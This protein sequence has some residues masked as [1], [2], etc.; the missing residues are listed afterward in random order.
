M[1]AIKAVLFDMDGV[2]IDSES[3]YKNRR[4]KFLKK[5]KY[6]PHCSMEF[7]GFNERAI[8]ETLVPE[9]IELREELHSQYRKYCIKNPIDYLGYGNPQVYDVFSKLKHDG[10]L[11]AVCSSSEPIIIS[12]FLHANGVD[13]YVDYVISGTQ[14]SQ[15]K[16]S[17]EIYIRAISALHVSAKQCLIVEDSS[18]GITAANASDAR[19]VRLSQYGNDQSTLPNSGVVIE[20]LLDILSYIKHNDGEKFLKCKY[21]NCERKYY[22]SSPVPTN[23]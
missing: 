6:S 3:F 23:L 2:L 19:V 7:T 12:N 13:H 4:S 10:I 9:D 15:N 17:P 5:V 16:P 14:C 18:I 20:N 21:T 1:E 22:G 11:I 8:W